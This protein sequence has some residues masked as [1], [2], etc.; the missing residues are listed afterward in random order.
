MKIGRIDVRE[1]AEMYGTPLYVYDRDVLIKS[2]ERFRNAFKKY[3]GN[4]IIA[5]ALKANSNPKIV[6]ILGSLGFGADAVSIGELFIAIKSGIDPKKIVFNGNNKQENEIKF[7]IEKEILMFNVD[8][9][10]ELKRISCIAEEYGEAVRVAFRI[11]PDVSAD[12]H[13]HIATGLKKSKFGIQIE[14]AY[15]AYSLAESLEYIVPI[16]IHTHIGSQILK[17]EPFIESAQ[18]IVDL[19]NRIEDKLSISIQYINLGG[20][21]GIAYREEE[22]ELDV[23]ELSD[24]IIPIIEKAGKRTLILEPGR[25]IVGRSGYLVTKAGY[26]KYNPSLGKIVSVDA[27][28][29]VLIR[30]MLYNAYHKVVNAEDRGKKEIVTI[31][32]PICESGDILAVKREIS[33]VKEGDLLVFFDVGAYGFSMASRYNARPLP[34]E[35][36]VYGNRSEVIRERETLE[37]LVS[38]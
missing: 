29:N 32:G 2:A 34:A 37:S 4:L 22:K 38:L 16:G 7:A 19:V 23:N 33:E 36:M 12:V 20:G 27:G 18:K 14:D 24:S 31:V 28:M 9:I 5:Y 35:I 11:N 1:L 25:Y 21:V 8:S 10:S 15:E 17:K 3:N 30:P 6:E 26:I 13:P